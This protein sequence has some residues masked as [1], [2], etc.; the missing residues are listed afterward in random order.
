MS[1]KFYTVILFL[2]VSTFGFSQ[3]VTTVSS[4]YGFKNK[5][6]QGF[7]NFENIFLEKLIFEGKNIKDKSYIVEIIEYNHGK[8]TSRNI[9]FDGTET[10]YFK[11]NTEKETLSFYI[12]LRDG[13]LKVQMHGKGFR[14]KKMYY[15]LYNEADTYALKDFLGSNSKVNIDIEKENPVLA[16]ITP[17]VHENGFSSY[18]EVAQSEVPTHKL[19]VHFK[20]PHYFII[21]IRFK[22]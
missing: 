13:K 1:S 22:G 10:D 8:E 17:T 7:I 2:V 14:S 9:L 3:A 11:I 4:E 6:L 5:D 20:I 12:K 15:N 21:N 18:C 19:G 16:I